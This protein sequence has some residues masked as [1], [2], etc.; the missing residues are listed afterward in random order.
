MKLFEKIFLV[1][2]GSAAMLV[3]VFGAFAIC[4][5]IFRAVFE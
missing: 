1:T 4:V 5:S 3:A 2:L